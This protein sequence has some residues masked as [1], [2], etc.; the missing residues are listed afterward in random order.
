MTDLI[1]VTQYT[2]DH[3]REGLLR[4]F[5]RSAKHKDFDIMVIGH[6]PIAKDICEEVDFFIYEKQNL[7]LT[8]VEQKYAMDYR[9]ESVFVTSTEAAPFNHH[10][11]IMRSIALG[12]SIAKS[13]GYEKVHYFEYDSLIND[14]SELIENSKLLDTYSAVYYNTMNPD[15]TIPDFPNSPVSLN[16]NTVSKRWFDFD[17]KYLFEHV[18]SETA[19]TV[20]HYEW[21]LLNE[22][23]V[24]PLRKSVYNFPNN[25]IVRALHATV[26]KSPWIVPVID[27]VGNLVLFSEN[28]D[29]S[30][31]LKVIATVNNEKVEHVT[32]KYQTWGARLLGK[33]E[34]INEVTI[35]INDRKIKHYDFSKIDRE[36]FAKRNKIT[37]L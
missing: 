7:L 33:F 12:L 36:V 15:E 32:V 17:Y 11:A 25:G 6:T 35:V 29:E 9:A 28:L 26:D 21:I 2:P 34:S 1:L 31:E 18:D 16:L 24:A 37:H 20:E 3:L 10:I 8:S 23:D 4:D 14:H 19:K 13:N 30:S 22:S 27:T 5:I